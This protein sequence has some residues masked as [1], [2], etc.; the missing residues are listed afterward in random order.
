MRLLL[1]L[2]LRS[3]MLM[4]GLGEDILIGHLAL[5]QRLPR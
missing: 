3:L 4:L 2:L 1:L 5:E